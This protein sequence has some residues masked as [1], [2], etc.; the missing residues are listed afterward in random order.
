MRI[1]LHH[2]SLLFR[3][4]FV[5][6]KLSPGN[7]E[8][9]F[10]RELVDVRWTRLALHRFLKS[11]IGNLRAAEIPDAFAEH[12]LS[13]V[14]HARLDEVVI[15]LVGDTGTASL[16]I[17]EIGLRPPIAQT[18]EVVVLST[19]VVEAVRNFVPDDH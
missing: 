2:Q 6:A 4:G 1:R 14:M 5:A 17:L 18:A 10:G 11:E 16:E 13:V 3:T 9:L 19:F 15:E 8:L 12:Q 7:E